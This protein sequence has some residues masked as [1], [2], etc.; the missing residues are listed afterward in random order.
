M[1][2]VKRILCSS[3]E[4]NLF[5]QIALFSMTGLCLSLALVFTCDVGIAG[6]WL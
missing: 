4:C 6:Q 2:N 1:S 5:N 3:L